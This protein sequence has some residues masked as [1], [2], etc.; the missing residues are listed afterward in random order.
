MSVRRIVGML[1]VAV[2]ICSGSCASFGASTFEKL[3]PLTSVTLTAVKTPMVFYRDNSGRAAYARNFA[4]LG[5]IQVNRSGQFRYFLWIGV[6]S[7]GPVPDDVQRR[8]GF[9]APVLFVDGEPLQLT[10][11][12]WSPESIGAS[13]GIY[14]KPVASSID[15]YYEISIDV[16]RLLA[17]AQDVRIS[18]S[19]GIQEN[20]EPWNDQQ[21]ARA[22]LRD[23]FEIIGY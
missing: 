7:T 12:G 21:A 6:W 22:N 3:D 2:L 16:V 8:D 20:Y 17:T 18:T 14:P 11:A 13:E 10:L 4:D 1:Q 19:G 15:A 5:P 23:F 9:E